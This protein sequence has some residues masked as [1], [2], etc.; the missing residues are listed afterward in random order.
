MTFFD[1][2]FVVPALI[3]SIALIIGLWI[4]GWGISA[5]GQDN[6]ITTTGSAS[7]GAVADNATWVINLQRTSFGSTVAADSTRV[8]NEAAAIAEYF[9]KQNL[10]SSSVTVAAVS[11][12]QNYSQDKN[13]PE[14][15]N[16]NDSVTVTTSDVQTIESMSRSIAALSALVS[17]GTVVSPSQ[18][19]Y[20][21]SNLSSMRVSLL[22]EAIKD[23]KARAVQIAKNGGGSVGP[24]KTA[25]SGVV[26]VLSPNS[27][28][29]EDYGQYDTS[30][31]QKQIM[32]TVRASFYV[33]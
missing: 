32:V 13:A 15:Y 7:Q 10:A 1:R 33:R 14:S 27:T 6:I 12:Y 9:K 26:Q 30:T 8:A 4:V 23:A 11:V 21:V 16:I 20:F 22:G 25:S 3:T 19:Q 28:N 5:R 2:P 18:P 29:V 17:S 24:L 31:I